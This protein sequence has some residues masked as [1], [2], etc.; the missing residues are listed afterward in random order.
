MPQI[1]SVNNTDG[2]SAMSRALKHAAGGH[3]DPGGETRAAER[4]T[5]IG[6]AVDFIGGLAKLAVGGLVGSTALVADG[7]H[8]FSDLLTDA[9]VIVAI[10]FG[11]READSNRPYGHGRIETLATLWLGSALLFVAG[12]I[13]WAGVKQLIVGAP[14]PTP[15]LWGIGVAVVALLSKEWIFHYTLRVARQIDSRLLAANAWHSRSD[16]LSTVVVLIGLVAAEFGVG[17]LDTVAAIFVGIMVGWIGGRLLW[18][19]SQELVDTAL[20]E[21]ER[22]RM[23][24]VAEAVPG[25]R[26][27]HELRGRSLGRD[28]VVDLHIVVP[29]RVSVSEGHEIGTEAARRLREAFPRVSDVTF[30]IDPVED[31]EENAPPPRALPLRQE[32]ER[33]LETHWAGHPAWDSRLAMDLHYLDQAVDIALYIRGL[34][35]KQGMEQAASELR[36]SAEDLTW[37][38]KLHLWQGPGKR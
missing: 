3:P 13:A 33:I 2:G 38:G 24:A 32:L 23:R 5:L 36:Q 35:P 27:V 17:W 19:S 26:G 4:V 20:P 1:S 8:S 12:G 22:M 16:A 11:R 37:L 9:L 34:P 25:V 18:E 30:H 28:T 21:N 6:A 15:G 31:T 14:P 29:A 10:R 7:I